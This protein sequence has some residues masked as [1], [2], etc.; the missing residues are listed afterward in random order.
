MKRSALDGAAAKGWDAQKAGKSL[1]GDNPY[2]DKRGRN[3]SMLT[4]S[5]A[6][7]TA[8]RRGFIE[9]KEGGPRP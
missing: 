6:F 1:G 8:W 9:A 5:R 2:S 4:W 7:R 3:G